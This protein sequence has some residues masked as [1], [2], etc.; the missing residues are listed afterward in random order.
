MYREQGFK[1]LKN[2]NGSQERIQ[3]PRT[4]AQE[5]SITAISKSHPGFIPLSPMQK[6]FIGVRFWPYRAG[7][8]VSI[9]GKEEVTS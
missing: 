9:V 3:T 6:H 2:K 1:M 5:Y 4:L 7:T 8:V